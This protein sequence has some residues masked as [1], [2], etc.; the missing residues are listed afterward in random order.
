[1]CRWWA[2][3]PPRTISIAQQL[4]EQ[5]RAHPG[6]A[7]VH[8]HQVVDHPEIRLNV[9]RSKAGQVGLTQRDVTSSLLISLSVA[10]ARWRPTQWLNWANGV[11]YNVGVQTPQYRVDSLDCAAAHADLGA[12][13]AP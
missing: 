4:A 2:A 11:S 7:D 12:P 8:V 10:A 13:P 9:D 5:D 3:T 6:A 1:M